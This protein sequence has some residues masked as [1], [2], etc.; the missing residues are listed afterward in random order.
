MSYTIQL[1]RFKGRKGVGNH[2]IGAHLSTPVVSLMATR[3]CN[4]D[5]VNQVIG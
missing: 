2:M 1:E 5:S 3:R 4:E